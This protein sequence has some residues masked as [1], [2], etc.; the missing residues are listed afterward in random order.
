[1]HIVFSSKEGGEGR[2]GGGEG[3]GGGGGQ[4]S[5]KQ[6]AAFFLQTMD[7]FYEKISDPAH[8]GAAFFAVCRGKV[9]D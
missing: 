9:R 5:S 8:N 6:C 1:M 7:A 2:G 3:E 4:P